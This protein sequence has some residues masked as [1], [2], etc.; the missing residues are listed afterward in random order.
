MTLGPVSHMRA[1][2]KKGL[3]NAQVTK[4]NNEAIARECI[5]LAPAKILL[6]EGYRVEAV[7]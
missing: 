7:G 1:N 6:A 2:R 3:H 4:S 5:L